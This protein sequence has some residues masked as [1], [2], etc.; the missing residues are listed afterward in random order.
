MEFFGPEPADFAN[1]TALNGAYLDGLRSPAAGRE[2]RRQFPDGLRPVLE[3]LADHHLQ[4]LSATPFLLFSLRERDLA[5]WEHI[6]AN[7]PEPDLFTHAPNR[8]VDILLPAI[9]YLWQLA[10]QN[11][12]A[13]RLV[14]GAA[15]AWCE[16]IAEF[17]MFELVQRLRGRGDLLRPRFARRTGCW[18]RLLGP[19]I[20]SQ[21]QLREAAHLACLQ[22]LLTDEPPTAPRRLQTAA[23]DNALPVLTL[24][25]RRRK[26]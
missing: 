16:L 10:R 6:A 1:V 24:L 20:S 4:R 15:P 12:Y 2:H 17:T 9:S 22:I 18:E 5:L 14:T 7:A 8:D 23:C 13:L 21:R 3:G 25:G 19:G 26:T 11:P